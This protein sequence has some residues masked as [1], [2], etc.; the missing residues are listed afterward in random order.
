MIDAIKLYAI[1]QNQILAVIASANKYVTIAVASRANSRQKLH[2]TYY[3]VLTGQTWQRFYLGRCQR[4]SSH[5]LVKRNG[6]VAYHH[7]AKHY[8]RFE[9]KVHIAVITFPHNSVYGRIS[10]IRNLQYCRIAACAQAVEPM[11]VGVCSDFRNSIEHNGINKPVAS[12]GIGNIATYA[13]LLRKKR[14]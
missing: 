2:S 8:R 11:L 13:Y 12:L 5:I 3:I 14:A 10:D 9:G 4:H 7:F 6:F 1:E